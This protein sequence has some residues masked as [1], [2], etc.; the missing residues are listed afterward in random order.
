MQIVIAPDAS[1]R[2]LYDETIDLHAL[3]DVSIQR[4]SHVE[5]N[6][7]GEWI[8]DL[9]PVGGPLLGPFIVRSAALIA[10]RDWLESNWLEPAP[11]VSSD[12]HIPLG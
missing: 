2:C 7:A 9:S 6:D 5:P 10:E 11:P 4:A 3:G 8:A 1:L 12:R